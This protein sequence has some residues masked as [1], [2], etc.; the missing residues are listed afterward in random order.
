MLSL[1]ILVTLLLDQGSKA[2]VQMMMYHGESI[3]VL[4]PVFYLT[5]IHN[6]GAA[7][8]LLAYQTPLFIAVAVLLTMGVLL[9]YQKLSRER[10]LLRCGLL[11]ILGG[12]LGNLTDRL[13]HGYVVD[14]IDFRVFPVFN[15]ADTAIVAGACLLVWELFKNEDKQQKKESEL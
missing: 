9:G 7:F 10:Y 2:I 8:G 14:F 11:L 12:T 15:L 3:P 1:I 6:P 4:P 13:R 5:Y